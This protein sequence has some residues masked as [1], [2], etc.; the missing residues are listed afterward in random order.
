MPG[1]VPGIQPTAR[2]GASGRMDPGDKHRDDNV[3][4]IGSIL[5][6]RTYSP[7]SLMAASN[8][9]CASSGVVM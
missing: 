5:A 3:Q 1:L 4:P 9:F 2:A 8:S 6:I 7:Q